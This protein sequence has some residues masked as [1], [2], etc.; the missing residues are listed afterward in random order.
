MSLYTAL[1]RFRWDPPGVVTR[2]GPH[3]KPLSGTG[4][5]LELLPDRHTVLPGQQG[6][7]AL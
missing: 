1:R 6:K 4:A 3:S 7:G 5:T 2:E